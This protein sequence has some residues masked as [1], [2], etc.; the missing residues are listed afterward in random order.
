RAGSAGTHGPVDFSTFRSRIVEGKSG[1]YQVLGSTLGA[2]QVGTE[3]PRLDV[4]VVDVT[5]AEP[6]KVFDRD[7][8]SVMALRIPHANLPTLAYRVE[9]RGMSVVFSSDQNGTGRKFVDFA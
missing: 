8:I 6:T 7:G 1:A 4:R 3:R 9:T 5:K 2:E